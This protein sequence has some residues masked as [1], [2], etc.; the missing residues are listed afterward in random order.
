MNRIKLL[1]EEFKLSQEELA[2]RLD[3][4][5]GVISMYENEARKPSY[6]VLLKLS[7]IFNC[8]IDYIVGNSNER[9]SND[10]NADL[11]K[12]GLSL[13]D[14]TPPTEEQ[15]KQIEE[16]AKYVLKDNKKEK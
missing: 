9:N 11:I 4:S 14:Y 5:K 2:L 10:F 15:K 1:R 12:I 6:E 3:L 8:S 16:F 7:E 13:K